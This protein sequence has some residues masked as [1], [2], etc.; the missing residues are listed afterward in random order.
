MLIT[1]E[2]PDDLAKEV[3]TRWTD[4]SRAALDS[5]ALEAYRSHVLSAAQLSRLLGFATRMQMDAFLEGA[6]SLQLHGSRLRVGLRDAPSGSGKGAQHW[7]G[8][9]AQFVAKQNPI[10]LIGHP[11]LIISR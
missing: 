5:L 3:E 7:V 6:R 1:L 2:L 8:P 9:C 10:R 11:R 4:L